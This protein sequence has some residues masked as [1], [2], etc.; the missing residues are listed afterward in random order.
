MDVAGAA[1]EKTERIL[2]ALTAGLRAIPAARLSRYWSVRAEGPFGLAPAHVDAEVESATTRLRYVTW[3]A[4]SVGAWPCVAFDDD[5][6]ARVAT[7]VVR[8]E[9]DL[10]LERVAKFVATGEVFDA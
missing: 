4:L 7:I 10:V 1:D 8:A 5:M 6:L 2:A 9:C 3:C